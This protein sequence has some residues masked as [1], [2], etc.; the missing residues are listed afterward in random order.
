MA[1]GAKVKW[2]STGGAGTTLT[3]IGR[4]KGSN[5][6]FRRINPKEQI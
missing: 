5:S 4:V 2:K 3:F 6:V 1:L